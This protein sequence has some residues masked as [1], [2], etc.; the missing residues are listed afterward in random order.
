MSQPKSFKIIYGWT[1]SDITFTK[2]LLAEDGIAAAYKAE[3]LKDTDWKLIDV[4]PNEE[5]EH[6]LS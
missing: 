3:E 4:I 2:Y 5:E 1:N 6:L